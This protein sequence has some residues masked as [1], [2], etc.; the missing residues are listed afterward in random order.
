MSESRILLVEGKDDQHTI[1]AICNQLGVAETFGIRIPDGNGKIR[2]NEESTEL[3]GVDNVLKALDLSL[4]AGSDAIKTIGIVVDADDNLKGRW[5]DIVRILE[6]SGYKSIPTIPETHGTII[7]Q[8]FL[9][10]FG[11]WLMPD[12]QIERGNLETFLTFLVPNDSPNW[13]HAKNSVAALE[14]KPFVKKESDH[15]AKAEIHTFLAWQ[16][17]PGKPFGQAITARYLRSENPKC[18]IFADW[19]MRLFAVES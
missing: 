18:G 5:K 9:P 15:T 12:N 7:S 4:T 17:D 13:Q 3:G 8:E 11:C 14:S 2:K 6:S 10:T 16:E 1:W 19:L